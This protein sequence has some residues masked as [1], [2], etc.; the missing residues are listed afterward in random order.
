MLIKF[1]LSQHNQ[2]DD[3]DDDDDD[4]EADN[5]FVLV[6]KLVLR[7]INHVGRVPAGLCPSTTFAN[8]HLSTSSTIST[9]SS[10]RRLTAAGDT[11]YHLYNNSASRLPSTVPTQ[12]GR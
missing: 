2:M 8:T 10:G 11:E 4:T 5:D 6:P 7:D 3:D 12:Y 9:T 1:D